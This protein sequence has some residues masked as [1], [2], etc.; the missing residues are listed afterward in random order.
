MTT[1]AIAIRILE[2]IGFC[3]LSGW[4]GPHKLLKRKNLIGADVTK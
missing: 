1:S 3:N 4:V 2:C